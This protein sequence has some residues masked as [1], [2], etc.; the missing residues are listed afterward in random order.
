MYET[1]L[2]AHGGLCAF[3]VPSVQRIGVVLQ[4]C[5][6]QPLVVAR[7]FS[8]RGRETGRGTEEREHSQLTQVLFPSFSTQSRVYF[9]LK[10]LASPVVL[11]G[12]RVQI[13]FGFWSLI[14]HLLGKKLE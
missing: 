8:R 2:W 4:G 3:T 12:W 11:G 7:D 10:I 1:V 14:S 6:L 9:C 5:V 13:L